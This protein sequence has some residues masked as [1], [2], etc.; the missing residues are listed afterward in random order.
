MTFV[1]AAVGVVIPWPLFLK[2]SVWD[3]VVWIS[4]MLMST[5]L[6]CGA[7][8]PEFSA[9]A[10]LEDL[11]LPLESSDSGLGNRDSGQFFDPENSGRFRTKFDCKG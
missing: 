10:D 2:Y 5:L 6:L 4:V 9:R 8:A 1:V 11:V 3:W 7:T